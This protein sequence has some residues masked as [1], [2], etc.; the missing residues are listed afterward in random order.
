MLRWLVTAGCMDV[1]RCSDMIST[2]KKVVGN[3]LSCSKLVVRVY[4][5]GGP[6]KRFVVRPALNGL[7]ESLLEWC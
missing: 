6:V 7:R 4:S 2:S 3:M 1:D 5:C